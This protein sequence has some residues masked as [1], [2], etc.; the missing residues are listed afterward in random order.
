[1]STINY[2]LVG[3][4]KFS[5]PFSK[6]KIFIQNFKLEEKNS[7][8]TI[9]LLLPFPVDWEGGSADS[10]VEETA[11]GG[12]GEVAGVRQCHQPGTARAGL[13]LG[14]GEICF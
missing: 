7:M 3:I 1:M 8:F 2:N 12:S 13:P 11:G 9:M 10:W 6:F 14:W 4:F 5:I